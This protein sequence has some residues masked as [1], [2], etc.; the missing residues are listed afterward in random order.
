LNPNNTEATETATSAGMGDAGARGH[1]PFRE[2]RGTISWSRAYPGL[3]NPGVDGVLYALEPTEAVEEAT[4]RQA[5]EDGN[6][7]RKKRFAR[8]IS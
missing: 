6:A 8:S 5:H 3:V 1:G 7:C 4:L 2:G